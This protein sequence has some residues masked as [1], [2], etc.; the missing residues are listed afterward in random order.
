[1]TVMTPGP[2]R[3]AFDLECARLDSLCAS[4]DLAGAAAS[5]D[6]LAILR[7]LA[8]PP[9][10]CSVWEL[11]SAAAVIRLTARMYAGDITGLAGLDRR[12]MCAW[13]SLAAALTGHQRGLAFAALAD[14]ALE[15]YGMLAAGMLA[16]LSRA[17]YGASELREPHA[18]DLGG[19]QQ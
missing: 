12:E 2:L 14:I 8:A 17:S 10:A 1:V 13:V 3:I 6:R 19:G 9:G 5:L 11:Q 7:P 16:H 15:R 18:A 4:R